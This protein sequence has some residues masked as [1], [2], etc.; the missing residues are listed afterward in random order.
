MVIPNVLCLRAILCTALLVACR[1]EL[2]GGGFVAAA[3]TT[4]AAASGSGYTRAATCGPGSGQPQCIDPSDEHGE[5]SA[6]GSTGE[7]ARL[8]AVCDSEE[9]VNQRQQQQQQ[10]PQR[11]HQK[12]PQQRVGTAAAAAADE[13]PTGVTPGRFQ[14]GDIVEL[15]NTEARGIQIVFPSL[16]KER[17][18]GGYRVTK[19]T[20]GKEVTN[21]PDKHLH[22]YV[23]YQEGG[24]ALCNIGEFKPARSGES[25]ISRPIIVQCTVLAYTPAASRGAMVLQGR[26]AVRVAKT[27]AN[28]EYETEL[29]VWKLQRRYRAAAEQ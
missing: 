27:K 13:G 11:K 16:V 1:L 14:T 2:R 18:A 3:T 7:A 28:E 17:E 15:Y 20:D 4:A 25:P 9:C 8:E 6:R 21:V 19:T 12:Q 5:E 23:P 10:K 26:Y 24:E 22:R 29:P